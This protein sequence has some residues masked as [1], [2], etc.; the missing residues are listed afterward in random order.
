MSGIGTATESIA[1]IVEHEMME[2]VKQLESCIEDLLDF[3]RKIEG[4]IL[5]RDEFMFCMDVVALYPSVP[6][7]RGKETMQ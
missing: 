4:L 1:G 6:K 3:L 7:E 5:E 2:G